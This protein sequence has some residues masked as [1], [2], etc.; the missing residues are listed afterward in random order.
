MV[1]LGYMK[2]V[3]IYRPNSENARAVE[4]FVHDIDRQENIH[5]EQVDVDSREGM[6][7][8]QLYGIETHPAIVVLRDDGQLIQHWA[9]ERLPLIQEVAAFAR[10]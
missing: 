4:S 5:I 6:D 7:M 8:L 2:T 10:G 9:G 1:D 3:V